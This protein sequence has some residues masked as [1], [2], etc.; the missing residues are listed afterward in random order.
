MGKQIISKDMKPKIIIQTMQKTFDLLQDDMEEAKSLHDDETF[1]V[2]LEA[3]RIQKELQSMIQK[4][5]K[6]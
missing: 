6:Q 3:L 1:K 2:Y 5:I 4:T